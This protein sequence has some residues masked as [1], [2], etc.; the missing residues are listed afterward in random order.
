MSNN[1]TLKWSLQFDLAGGGAALKQATNLLQQMSSQVARLGSQMQGLSGSM[2]GA[3]SGGG[4]GGGG[5]GNS[6]MGVANGLRSALSGVQSGGLGAAAS[7]GR[8]A[9]M[10]GPVGAVLAAVVAVGVGI[11]KAYDVIDDV[12]E[13]AIEGFSMRTSIMRSYT[14][15]LGSAEKAQERFNKV[16]QLGL[17]TEFTREQIQSVDTRLT[18]AG[19]RGEA[20]DKMLLTIADLA[21]VLPENERKMGMNRAG[22][23][24][25]QIQQKG[26]LQGEEIRQL[27]GFLN[28]GMF[29]EEIAKATGKKLN[30]VDSLIRDKKITS[31]VAIAAA[32]QA[33]LRQLGTSKL[34]EFSTGAA[35]SISTMLSNKEEAL[36]N[37]FLNIDP[38]SLPSYKKYK[39]AIQGV[40]NAM[41]ASTE[42]GKNV[43]FALEDISNIGMG[44]RAAGNTFLSS[45]IESFAGSYRKAVSTLGGDS[46][47]VSNSFDMLTEAMKKVGTMVGQVGTLVGYLSRG[48]E[49]AG[50]YTQ[51]FVDRFS[52]VAAWFKDFG[53]IFKSFIPIGKVVWEVVKGIASA[54]IYF[55]DSVKSVFSQVFV[56]LAKIFEGV[57]TGSWSKIKEGAAF[58]TGSKS[59]NTTQALDKSI[60]D[61]KNASFREKL[62]ELNSGSLGASDAKQKALEE[63]IEKKKQEA[64]TKSSAPA[65]S[66]GGSGRG[67]SDGGIPISFEYGGKMLDLSKYTIN[68]STL[69]VGAGSVPPALS[70]SP[71]SFS[72]RIDNIN[73]YIQGGS[74]SPS[75]IA[76]EVYTKLSHQVG[77]ITRSPDRQVT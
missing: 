48:F 58:L 40:T 32:Q 12:T 26:V 4:I 55:F 66:S 34:G 31:D 15:I 65:A 27:A 6:I 60:E 37:A 47:S 71:N 57:T 18:V 16:S 29:K 74:S 19:F 45:F 72:P 42:S 38:E 46:K 36:Q 50:E 5:S 2:K 33:T 41:D 56:G 53:E 39:D 21:S 9:S 63:N 11:K 20:A 14:T 70:A 61:Q 1:E 64:L 13:R 62:K 30:E 10:A 68:P 69:S 3:L 52:A 23:A 49:K 43:K 59:T 22:L 54:F 51:Y 7:L 35:G 77:R 25:S 73:I 67:K 28:I 8:M 44:F 76:D 24:F 17:K 75:E